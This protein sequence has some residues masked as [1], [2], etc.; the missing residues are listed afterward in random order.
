MN[1][2]EQRIAKLNRAK[3][4]SHVF[5]SGDISIRNEFYL[6]KLKPGD[7]VY[8]TV[9][10]LRN[11]DNVDIIAQLAEQG[12]VFSGYG[13]VHDSEGSWDGNGWKGQTFPTLEFTLY[14][15]Q[16]NKI[17]LSISSK[18]VIGQQIW[19]V[20]RGKRYI[21]KPKHFFFCTTKI[22][23]KEVATEDGGMAKIFTAED[24][25]SKENDNGM[26]VA[27]KSWDDSKT[28]PEFNQF[29]GRKIRITIE[30]ID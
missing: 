23:E 19:K 4:S 20:K 25:N 21:V 9:W 1:F 13:N 28:H 6:N 2:Y 5:G 16:K 24:E 7:V 12:M 11:V 8:P 29:V 26:F 22:N 14:D 3:L 17:N 10:F 18:F 15:L 27:I 30:T